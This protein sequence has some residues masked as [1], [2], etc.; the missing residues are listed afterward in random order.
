LVSRDSLW[1][2]LVTITL[3]KALDLRR[4]ERQQKRGGGEVLGESELPDTAD[5]AVTN[6]GLEQV[7][8]REPTP[9][10]AVQVAEE[11]SRLLDRLDNTS[12]QSLALLKM[13][14]Y[15]NPEL[16]A[17]LGCGLRTIERKLRLIRKI[18]AMEV[19]P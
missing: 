4:H 1:R 8:G 10:F 19:A 5:S 9:E 11:C 12:L 16:A 17:R 13:E 18:W 2:M 3:R 6:A 14:G 15:T 7:I